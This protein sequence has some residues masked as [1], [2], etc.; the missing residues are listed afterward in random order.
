[1][2]QPLAFD[3]S[4]SASAPYVTSV[5][6]PASRYLPATRAAVSASPTTATSG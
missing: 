5:L 2:S 6:Q 1:V 4:T 3:T